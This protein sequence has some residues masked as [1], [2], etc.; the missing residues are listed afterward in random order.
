MFTEV[1]KGKN[2]MKTLHL[3]KSG[4][5]GLSI[6]ESFE[7]QEKHSVLTGIVMSNEFLIFEI[8]ICSSFTGLFG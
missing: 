8:S 2:L 7:K 1:I 6:S 5:R 3:E 4:I